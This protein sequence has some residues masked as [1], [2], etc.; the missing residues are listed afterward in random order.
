MTEATFESVKGKLEVIAPYLRHSHAA[1]V[2]IKFQNTNGNFSAE[3][4]QAGLAKFKGLKGTSQYKKFDLLHTRDRYSTNKK[5][6]LEN[7]TG[8]RA[9][10]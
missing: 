9:G 1:K 7:L 2:I 8:T 6:K 10:L 3:N 4:F 5:A